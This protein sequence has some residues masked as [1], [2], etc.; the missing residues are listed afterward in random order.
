M[1]K[2]EVY[3]NT[4]KRQ[5][6]WRFL[7]ILNRQHYWRFLWYKSWPLKKLKADI[8]RKKLTLGW[9]RQ[10]D[11]RLHSAW[12]KRQCRWRYHWC[13]QWQKRHCHV[14][15]TEG[16]RQSCWRFAWNF[17]AGYVQNNTLMENL[18]KQPQMGKLF[19]KEPHLG[20]FAMNLQCPMMHPSNDQLAKSSIH[21]CYASASI[22][23]IYF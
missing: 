9:W 21:A 18:S 12:P 19:V 11:Q 14:S 16:M 17:H 20:K 22:N 4:L 8:A 15:H 2:W 1:L 6:E 23:S 5:R 3:L 13:R 10:V 7:L